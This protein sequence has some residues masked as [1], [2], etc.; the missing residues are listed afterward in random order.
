MKVT[1]YI[2]ELVECSNLLW[3]DELQ[4][5][6]DSMGSAFELKE[7][8]DIKPLKVIANDGVT[9]RVKCKIELTVYLDV[10]LGDEGDFMDDKVDADGFGKG[11]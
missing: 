8:S 11:K 10:Y 7:I 2:K 5:T 1:S 9:A 4:L 3:T 6:P